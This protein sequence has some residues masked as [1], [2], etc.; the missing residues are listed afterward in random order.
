MPLVIPNQHSNWTI[1]V[2]NSAATTSAISSVSF[3]T[4]NLSPLDQTIVDRVANLFRDGLKGAWDNVWLVGPV[5]VVEGTGGVPKVWLNTTLE[6]G[7]ATAADYAPPAVSLVVS[8]QTG[9]AGRSHRGRIY[10]PGVPETVINEGGNLDG[11]YVTNMQTLF[12]ALL[13][14]INGDAAVDNMVLLHDSST[15]GAP[16]PDVIT[17][18]TVRSPVG[19]MRPR[20]RR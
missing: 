4:D 16:A 10:L 19:T 14:S 17:A 18:L 5:K 20:Q 15:P 11:T 6:A 13:G 1:T 2:Q 7:T 8:K 9:L 12:T 3:A